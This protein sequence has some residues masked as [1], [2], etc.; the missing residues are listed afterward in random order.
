MARELPASNATAKRLKVPAEHAGDP[1][2]MTYGDAVRD[3]LRERINADPVMVAADVK[4]REVK[5]DV[6]AWRTTPEH[7]AMQKRLRDYWRPLLLAASEVVNKRRDA[8]LAPRRAAAGWERMDAEAKGDFDREAVADALKT[9]DREALTATV[10]ASLDLDRD[11]E[12]VSA[13]SG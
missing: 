11:F 10:R 8:I 6:A 9:I 1:A 3:V 2:Q 13:I 5:A 4:Y 12:D 7:A